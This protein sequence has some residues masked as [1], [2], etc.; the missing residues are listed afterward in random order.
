MASSSSSTYTTI[1][2]TGIMTRSS[3][4]K[5]CEYDSFVELLSVAVFSSLHYVRI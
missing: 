2:V 1:C 3:L 4:G 5:R